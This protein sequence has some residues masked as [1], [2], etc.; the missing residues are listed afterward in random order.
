V[1]EAEH[2]R[3]ALEQVARQTPALILL[4]LMMPEM[5]GFE[6]LAEL[7]RDEERR[8]IPVVIVT[9]KELTADEREKLNGQVTRV[10]QKGGG[11]RDALLAQ[12]HELVAAG[13]RA[14]RQPVGSGGSS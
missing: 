2:G 8:G 1:V 13:A 4:D 11:T 12:I 3:A 6:F 9:A 14:A 5:D 7:R 10:I